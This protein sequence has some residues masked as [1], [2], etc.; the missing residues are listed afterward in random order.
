MNR[1]EGNTLGQPT[2]EPTNAKERESMVRTNN[3]VKLLSLALLAA[4]L[5]VSS[6]AGATGTPG[7][8][9]LLSL[10][11]GIGA[12]EAAMG[13]AGVASSQGAAAVFWN[14]A[15]NVF[16]D[17]DTNLVLQH[18]RYLGLFSHE[19]AAV[20]H[21]AGPGVIGFMFTGLYSDDI[22][23]YG[24]EP[25]GVPE[26]TFSPYDVAFGLSWAMPL[27]ERFAVGLNTKLAYQKI[28]MYSDSGLVFDFFITHHSLIEGLTFAASATNI[29]GQM[30]LKDQPFDLPQAFRVGMAWS[31]AHLAAGRLTVTG[32]LVFPN[33]TKEKAHLGLEW[34]LIP[35]LTLRGGTKVNYDL[36]GWTAG[37]GFR[38]GVLGIDYAYEDTKIEG[39]DAGHKFSLN[40]FW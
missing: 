3:P 30:N 16:V 7:Q 35:E 29:G 8:S 32:D 18:Y 6:T 40:L 28:D 31:P 14:P 11:M 19:S 33:D 39:F 4:L 24:S 13:G 37:A 2:T 21:R 5:M 10:R 20:A 1:M 34:R 36:Q 38:T 15:N 25:V 23:R 26:G 9:G 22:D 12:R 17:F 27:G